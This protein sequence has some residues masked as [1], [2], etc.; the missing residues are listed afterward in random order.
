[1]GTGTGLGGSTQKGRLK[2]AKSRFTSKAFTARKAQGARCVC[3]IL[4]SRSLHLTMSG[5]VIFTF[6]F[7]SPS[8]LP[9]HL[10]LINHVYLA[11]VSMGKAK[12]ASKRALSALL[13][14][15]L[16]LNAE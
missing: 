5:S 11:R 8:A 4:T 7:V 12:D 13:L 3:R 14:M 15:S 2:V 6:V 1:M 10:F 16:T 9:P